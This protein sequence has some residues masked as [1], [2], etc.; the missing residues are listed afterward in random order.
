[1]SGKRRLTSTLMMVTATLAVTELSQ[2]SEPASQVSDPIARIQSLRSALVQNGGSLAVRAPDGRW[3][4]AN[5]TTQFA[6]NFNNSF[7]QAK[8]NSCSNKC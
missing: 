6:Q 1:M 3:T 2:R 7:S 5:G 8:E 4:A